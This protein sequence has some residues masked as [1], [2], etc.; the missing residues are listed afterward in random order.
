[1]GCALIL[2][3]G[4]AESPSESMTEEILVGESTASL[5]RGGSNGGNSGGQNNVPQ[6]NNTAGGGA[7][8]NMPLASV[9]EALHSE[10]EI[11]THLRL[12]EHLPTP[13][14]P[15][16]NSLTA[17]KIELG[18]YLFYDHR[19]SINQRQVCSSCHQQEFGFADDRVVPSGTSG[20]ILRRNSQGLAN[21]GYYPTL[22][23]SNHELLDLEHQLLVPQTVDDPIE[24]GLTPENE[25]EILGRLRTDSEYPAWFTQAFPEETS[26]ITVDQITRPSPA[27]CVSWSLETVR[28]IAS[29][30]E[31]RQP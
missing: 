8:T 11:R 25:S 6:N 4:C 29:R 30:G 18:R 23:W 19:L 1:M 24:L 22:T 13:I 5:D 3:A 9:I 31:T 2:A 17:A 27:L 10:Q 16:L 20:E 21:V 12:P 26:T 7:A 28:L 15:T 14:I